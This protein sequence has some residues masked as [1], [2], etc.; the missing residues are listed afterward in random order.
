MAMQCRICGSKWVE[1][2][3]GLE[4][5]RRHEEQCRKKW[6]KKIHLKLVGLDGNAFALLGEFRKQA[7][8]E[9]WMN[10]EIE[11]VTYAAKSGDY[12]HLLSVL[13][14]HCEEGGM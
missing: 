12:N 7:R 4:D 8:K 10:E 9:G 1:T 3:E 13:M 11:I 6:G 5:L 2:P 14:E